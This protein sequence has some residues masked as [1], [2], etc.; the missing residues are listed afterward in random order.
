MLK[1]QNCKPLTT[2]IKSP[3]ATGPTS[4]GVVELAGAARQTDGSDEVGVGDGAAELHQGNVVVEEGV[5]VVGMDDDPRHGA[6]LFVRVGTALSLSSQVNGPCRWTVSGL[7]N[8][9]IKSALRWGLQ[10]TA[11]ISSIHHC[12]IPLCRKPVTC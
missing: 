7:Y 12:Q 1:S 11:L 3:P 4:C 2:L 8:R 5:V 6:A 9:K 10:L